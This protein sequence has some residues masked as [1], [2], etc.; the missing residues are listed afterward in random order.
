[1]G[2]RLDDAVISSAGVTCRGHGLCFDLRTGASRRSGLSSRFG[3]PRLAVYRTWLEQGR[4]H[5]QVPG[6][7]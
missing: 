3:R 1:M 2:R 7:A 6:S 5:V 4:L